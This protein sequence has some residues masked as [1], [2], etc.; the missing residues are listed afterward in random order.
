MSRTTIA[1]LGAVALVATAAGCGGDSSS[2][3]TGATTTA[4]AAS[5]PKSFTNAQYQ[6]AFSIAKVGKTSIAVI[7]TWPPPYQHYTDQYG[8]QCYEWNDVGQALYNMCFK[9]NGLLA[10]KVIG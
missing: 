5:Q 1:I 3:S 9:K 6:R 2:S 4:Q 7:K 8:Q 10:L